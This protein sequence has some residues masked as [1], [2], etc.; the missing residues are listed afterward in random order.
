MLYKFIAEKYLVDFFSRGTIRIGTIY[1]FTDTVA[2]TSARSDISEG[3]HEILREITSRVEF[4]NI[5]NEPI[6]NECIKIKLSEDSKLILENTRLSS[7]RESG[8]GFIFCTSRRYSKETFEKWHYDSHDNDA[9][10]AIINPE[11]FFNAITKRIHN[12]IYQY[13]NADVVY[14]PDPIPFDSIHASLNPAITKEINKYSWQCENRSIWAPKMP[15]SILK[16]FIIDVPE[17]IQ[18]CKPLSY[19]RNGS[20]FNYK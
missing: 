6:I 12:S 3:K 20:I 7:C 8:N 9:C 11:A 1:D 5:E 19:I 17:A 13:I 18:Y 14:T 4:S 16:P 10:Y 2:H 15:P